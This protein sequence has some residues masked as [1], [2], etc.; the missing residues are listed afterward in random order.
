M[1]ILLINRDG[2]VENA[3]VAGEDWEP[4]EGYRS[5]EVADD[6]PAGPGWTADGEGFA[7]PPSEPAVTIDVPKAPSLYAVAMLGVSDCQISGIELASR[8]S[9][10]LWMDVGLYYIF[11]A[12]TQPDTAYIAK[13]YRDGDEVLRVV[14]KAAD[15]I[16]VTAIAGPGG[17]AVDPPDLTIEIIRIV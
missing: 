14:E 11:F 2:L 5:V 13:A 1:K 10:A 3:V 4:P 12:E 6:D 8:F 15:Y 9:A 16:V 7:P 17:A